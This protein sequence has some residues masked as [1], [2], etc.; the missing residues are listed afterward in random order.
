[1]DIRLGRV[2]CHVPPYPA[3]DWLAV[4][5]TEFTVWDLIPGMCPDEEHLVT[6]ALLENQIT[7]QEFRDVC[8]Q[9][10]A[11]ATGR[12]WWIAVRLSHIAA[13]NWE[14]VGGNL[15]K[16]SVD[17][18]RISIGQWLDAVLLLC[19]EGMKPEQTTMFLSQLEMPPP[20]FETEVKEMEM[21]ASA[22]MAMR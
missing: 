5:M 13:A 8:L 16:N 18:S 7:V 4:L 14:S 3:A 11:T 10:I 22:F 9:V 17:A 21:S 12:P 15:A 6:K 1:M 19:L 20:G 2:V